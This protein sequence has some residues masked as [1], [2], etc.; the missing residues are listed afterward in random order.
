MSKKEIFIPIVYGAGVQPEVILEIC[1]GLEEEGVPF[2]MHQHQG[3]Q[4][5]LIDHADHAD[6][7]EAIDAFRSP[8]QVAISIQENGTLSLYHE[9]LDSGAPYMEDS[10][11]H[12]RRLGKNA[13]RLVKGL[14]LYLS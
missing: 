13:A 6:H 3:Q 9:K 1:A 12:A 5:H 14:P 4:S 10:W 7:T 2:Q 11:E 8:L